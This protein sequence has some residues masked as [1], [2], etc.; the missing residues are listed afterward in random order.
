MEKSKIVNEEAEDYTVDQEQD[1]EDEVNFD[2]LTQHK[3]EKNVQSLKKK[4]RL[5][6]IL[7]HA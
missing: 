2:E 5:I 1:E 7:E 4:K 3:I 6:V